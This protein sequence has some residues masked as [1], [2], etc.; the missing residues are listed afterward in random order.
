MDAKQVEMQHELVELK[1]VDKKT[2]LSQKLNKFQVLVEK[3]FQW[4]FNKRCQR[5]AN[6]R[7]LV[8][9]R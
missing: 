1:D 6:T 2:Q 7:Y 8:K 5:K 3:R 9:M 4:K